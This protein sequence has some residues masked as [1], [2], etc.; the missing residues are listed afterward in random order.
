V[1]KYCDEDEHVCLSVCVCVCVC[2]CLSV[3]LSV[4]D[5]TSG[6]TQAIFTNFSVHVAYGR[7]SLLLRQDRVT[8]NPKGKGQFLLGV[9]QLQCIVTHSLQMGSTGK[10]M[11]GLGVHSAGNV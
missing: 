11:M 10:E 9:P 7:G 8:K 5:H 2:V 1:A 6:T 3:C 4:R